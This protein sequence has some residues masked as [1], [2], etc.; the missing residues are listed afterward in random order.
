MSVEKY[1]K[2]IYCT[3]IAKRGKNEII[4]VY[5]QC[6][7]LLLNIYTQRASLV[8]QMVKKLPAMWE[9]WV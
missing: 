1:S 5:R 7:S 4:H 2:P 6:T 8:A 9:T 3:T